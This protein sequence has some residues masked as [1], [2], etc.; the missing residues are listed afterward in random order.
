MGPVD[1]GGAEQQ[2]G[3]RK[4]MNRPDF[5]G[6]WHWNPLLLKDPDYHG[7]RD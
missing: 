2:I 4:I 5:G 3:D 6:G 7:R 1:L